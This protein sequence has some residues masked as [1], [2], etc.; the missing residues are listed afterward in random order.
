MAQ[1]V[2]KQDVREGLYKVLAWLRKATSGTWAGMYSLAATAASEV[3]QQTTWLR[4]SPQAGRVCQHGWQLSACGSVVQNVAQVTGDAATSRHEE[5]LKRKRPDSSGQ[6]E[7]KRRRLHGMMGFGEPSF[8]NPGGHDIFSIST[9]QPQHGPEPSLTDTQCFSR[10]R[11][12]EEAMENTRR[13][14]VLEALL[15]SGLLRSQ[16]CWT[17]GWNVVQ[18]WAVWAVTTLRLN[19]AEAIRQAVL[20]LGMALPE[21]T[22]EVLGF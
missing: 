14:L 4:L 11:P 18:E 5:V 2:S 10:L 20:V 1:R 6:T 7:A 8:Q 16:E 22:R 21:L 9:S 19:S 12:S 17:L 13:L 15:S 3:D